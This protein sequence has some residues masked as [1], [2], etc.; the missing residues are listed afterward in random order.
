[1][2][3]WPAGVDALCWGHK[4]HLHAYFRD[5]AIPILLGREDFFIHFKI[6]FDERGQRFQL[7]PYGPEPEA[8]AESESKPESEPEPEAEPRTP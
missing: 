5:A 4:I 8:E 7:E 6:Q 2:K 3:C 1:M